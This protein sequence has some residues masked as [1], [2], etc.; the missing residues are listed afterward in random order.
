[1]TTIQTA[2]PHCTVIVTVDAEPEVM[3]ELQAHARNGLVRFAE[4]KGFVSGALHASTDG[5]RIVQYLQWETEADHLD[6]MH[7]PRWDEMPSTKRIMRFANRT[8]LNHLMYCA[9]ALG[10]SV[11]R[12]QSRGLTGNRDLLSP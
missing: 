4:L 10:D 12:R 5:T 2:S 8:L 6:C 7:D 9:V 3:P 11:W 1:M